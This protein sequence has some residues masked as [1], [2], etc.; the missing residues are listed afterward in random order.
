MNDLDI[1]VLFYDLETQLLAQELSTGW[2]DAE[3]LRI[4]ILA[5]TRL[6][7]QNGN[8]KAY[9]TDILREN[10]MPD[11][12]TSATNSEAVVAWGAYYYNR[13]LFSYD[14][15]YI[16]K[17]KPVIDLQDLTWKH[18]NDKTIQL[19]AL[20]D[21]LGAKKMGKSGVEAVE[22]FRKGHF[23]ELSRF[24][25]WDINI[26]V[27]Y[28]IKIMNTVKEGSS[29]LVLNSDKRQIRVNLFEIK[30]DIELILKRPHL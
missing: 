19:S 25:L 29:L 15:G 5:Y 4:S 7:W 27:L 22:Y 14:D 28:W 26:L 9:Y 12:F 13:L 6:H 2:V 16:L 1:R 24:V 3:S 21:A 17:S 8:V 11:L 20:S 10:E 18:S 30:K 23:Y